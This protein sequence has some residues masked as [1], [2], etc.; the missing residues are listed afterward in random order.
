MKELSII[1]KTYDL[2]KYYVPIIERFPKVYK[3]T[4]GDRI[5]N[6]L[7]DLLEGLIKAKYEKNKLNALINLNVQLDIL[8]HQTRLILDF[9]LI[10]LKRYQ[11]VSQKIDEI[12]IELGGWIKTQRQRE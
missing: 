2:I 6:Q 8:R 9:Q 4:A 3:F 5:V 1:Q 7:Y 11:Y 12:G 10:D